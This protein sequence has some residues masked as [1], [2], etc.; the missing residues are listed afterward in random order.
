MVHTGYQLHKGF[1]AKLLSGYGSG[2]YVA[3]LQVVL[4]C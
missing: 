3:I 1:P 4:V 2:T